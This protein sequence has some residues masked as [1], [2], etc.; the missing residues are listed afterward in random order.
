MVETW[1]ALDRTLATTVHCNKCCCCG[2]HVDLCRDSTYSLVHLVPYPIVAKRQCVCSPVRLHGNIRFKGYCVWACGCFCALCACFCVC[3]HSG[4]NIGVVCAWLCVCHPTGVDHRL[5]D[6]CTA[7]YTACDAGRFPVVQGLLEFPGGKDA[8]SIA[9]KGGWNPLHIAAFNG[10]NEIV[11]HMVTTLS[12]DVNATTDAGSTA[13]YV[14]AQAGRVDVVRTLC[15]LD[16]HRI[17]VNRRSTQ[18]GA[19]PLIVAAKHG[20]LDVVRTL[21]VA[22]VDLNATTEHG[23]NAVHTAAIHRKGTG[24]RNGAKSTHV[25]MTVTYCKNTFSK[26]PCLWY[27]FVLHVARGVCFR[28]EISRLWVLCR[29]VFYSTLLF[30]NLH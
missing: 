22:G 11:Q 29:A 16:R 14:A 25:T 4:V 15:E 17:D 2:A 30:I 5:D 9:R 23:I 8:V 26:L 28:A 18:H 7:L 3:V 19:T 6:G 10:H 21:V 20:H 1:A 24:V 27:V 13:L 12:L